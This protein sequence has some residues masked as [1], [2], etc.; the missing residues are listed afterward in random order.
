MGCAEHFI[1]NH[2]DYVR[3]PYIGASFMVTI[4]QIR[5]AMHAQ[6]F[7]PFKLCL[8]GGGFY[9]VRHPDFISIPT[10]PQATDI[11]VSDSKGSH[12][13]AVSRIDRIAV[14]TRPTANP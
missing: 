5:D 1:R 11:A 12:L 14:Q 6:P 10:L 9:T 8:V 3:K 2:I 4:E 13:I 7:L